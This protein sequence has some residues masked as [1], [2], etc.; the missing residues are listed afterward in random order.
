MGLK[1]KQQKMEGE[2]H[3]RLSR[4]FTNSEIFSGV[5]SPHNKSTQTLHKGE[6]FPTKPSV[7]HYGEGLFNLDLDLCIA[8]RQMGPY[9]LAAHRVCS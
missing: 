4:C 1:G 7:K 8:R 2:S 5:A 3:G 6:S 9:S